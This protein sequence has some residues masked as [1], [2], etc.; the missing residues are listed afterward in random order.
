MARGYRAC[1]RCRPDQVGDTSPVVG[2]VATACRAIAAA[3]AR[4][5]PITRIARAAGGSAVQVQRAFRSLLGITPHEYVLACRRRQ[6]I[7]DL[8]SG[9]SVTDA[10]F[11]AGFGSSSRMYSAVTLSGM[12]PSTYGRGGQGAS[13][14]WTTVAS[15]IGRILVAATGTGV[16][17][18]EVGDTEARLVT[19]LRE[20]FPRATIAAGRSSRLAPYAAVARAIAAGERA[21]GAVPVD[22]RGTAFQ[23]KVWRA[24]T[25]IPG[26]RTRTYTELAKAIGKP[27]AVRAVARACATNPVSLVIPCHRVVGSDGTLRGYRWGVEVK[28]ALLAA[29]RVGGSAE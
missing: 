9:Q 23:W 27:S 14:E 19:A 12:R 6:F 20:E 16:C 18:V 13:I 22:I 1:R 8:R 26:G 29:E 17:F 10:T 11:S 24:L 21:P 4:P 15:P 3:P 25:A 2:R 7:R 28:R 5:W